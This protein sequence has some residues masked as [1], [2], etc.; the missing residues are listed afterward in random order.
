LLGLY[1][2]LKPSLLGIAVT[3]GVYYYFYQVFKNKVEAIAATDKKRGQGD[4]STG[5]FSWL[6]CRLIHKQKGVIQSSIIVSNPSIQFII[7]E[8]LSKQL[9]TK[10]AAKKKDVPNLIALEIFII[11]A[12]AKLGLTICTYPLFVV[13]SRL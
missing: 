12:F 6:V 5:M 13:K 4:G 9:K 11:G 8:M 7:I 3:Q 2:G 1:S 10:H